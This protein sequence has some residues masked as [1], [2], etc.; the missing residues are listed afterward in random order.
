MHWILCIVFKAFVFYAFVFSEFL[1]FLFVFYAFVFFAFVF[2]PFVF[3]ALYTMHCSIETLQPLLYI[4]C[5]MDQSKGLI[6]SALVGTIYLL[7]PHFWAN[8]PQTLDLGCKWMLL[9]VYKVWLRLTV[10]KTLFQGSSGILLMILWRHLESW[11][12]VKILSSTVDDD[13]ICQESSRLLTWVRNVLLA[14][15]IDMQ[16]T[17]KR[18]T[19]SRHR[20][21]LIY[22][23]SL[24]L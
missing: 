1:F 8:W 22:I 5:T 18:R 9:R 13:T 24:L 6:T 20:R 17:W 21:K 10:R 2:Y 14:S 4:Q 7:N 23:A 15:L 11:F 19:I 12:L 16:K 3:Y